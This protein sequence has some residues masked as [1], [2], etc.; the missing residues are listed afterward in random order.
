MLENL[1]ELAKD[2]YLRDYAKNGFDR[3][4]LINHI[5]ILQNQFVEYNRTTLDWIWEE[6]GY[7]YT[8]L[9]LGEIFSFL[10]ISLN[11]CIKNNNSNLITLDDSNSKFIKDTPRYYL[12]DL[13]YTLESNVDQRR[14]KSSKILS[15]K[16]KKS[17]DTFIVQTA[18]RSSIHSTFMKGM[19]DASIFY[20][21]SLFI[22][23]ALYK[24]EKFNLYSL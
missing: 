24:N 13:S 12:N 4:V 10:P 14:H 6:N 3:F 16:F 11:S 7:C 19:Y 5:Q 22:C 15:G 18:G 20:G 2:L 9:S 17:I 8:D 1:T 21:K 23:N